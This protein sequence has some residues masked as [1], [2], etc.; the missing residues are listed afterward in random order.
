[1]CLTIVTPEE[2][3]IKRINKYPNKKLIKAYKVFKLVKSIQKIK[4]KKGDVRRRSKLFIHAMFSTFD[5]QK[6]WNETYVGSIM[7]DDY[8]DYPAGFHS[9]TTI[10]G[11]TNWHKINHK[12][13]FSDWK[14]IILPVYFYKDH[15]LAFGKQYKYACIITDKLLIQPEDY[16]QIMKEGI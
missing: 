3:K 16:K 12:G 15:I 6:G 5:Y 1:M 2:T 9:F 13:D 8:H 7:A 10:E 14:T 4:T 11:A